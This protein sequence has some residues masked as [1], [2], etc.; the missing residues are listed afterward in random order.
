MYVGAWFRV[1]EDPLITSGSRH[2]F[3]F[4]KSIR[5][6]PTQIIAEV[7]KSVLQNGYFANEEN[8]LLGMINDENK[9][10]QV[11]G[12][13]KIL[14]ARKRPNNSLRE[15][16]IPP[17]NF[18]CNSYVDMIFWNEI[19]VHE[20]PFTKNIT[21][22][23]IIK[24]IQSEERIEVPPFP[25]HSQAVEALVQ[26]VSTSSGQ[27]LEDALDGHI[28]NKLYARSICPRFNSKKDFKAK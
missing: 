9:S 16:R 20:P 10:I 21:E 7:R 22:E 18:E 6:M 19:I 24:Y 27:V 1:K 13:T 3:N 12:F 26:T 23:E 8:I 11:D 17:I 15:F 2:L 14:Q 25:C 28:K 5:I 4:I